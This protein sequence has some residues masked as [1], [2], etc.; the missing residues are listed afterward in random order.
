MEEIMEIQAKSLTF[1]EKL[2]AADDNIKAIYN[3]MCEALVDKRVKNRVTKTSHNFTIKKVPIVK[4]RVMK[5]GL[6][7]YFALDPNAEEY[8]KVPHKDASDK[9]TYAR[10]PFVF[11][12]ASNLSVKR[13]KALIADVLK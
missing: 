2:N 4:I 11:K 9:K 8:A 13:A 5:K 6:Q 7:M 1:E 12:V 3:E 10:T